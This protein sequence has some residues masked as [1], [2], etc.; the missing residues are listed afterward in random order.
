MKFALPHIPLWIVVA[1]AAA[2]GAGSIGIEF[3]APRSSLGPTLESRAG[4]YAAAGFVASLVV[5][6][7]GRFARLLR[8][9]APDA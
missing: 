3:L 2:I 7:G 5:L 4:F 6:V 9:K 1:A 8:E